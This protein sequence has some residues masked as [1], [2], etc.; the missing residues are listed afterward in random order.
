M[1]SFLAVLLLLTA[2][3]CSG[4]AQVE[5][6]LI[7][8]GDLIYVEVFDTPELAQTVRVSDAGTVRLELIVDLKL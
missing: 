4:N 8:P 2:T 3:A 6:M 5:S 1:R 7:G